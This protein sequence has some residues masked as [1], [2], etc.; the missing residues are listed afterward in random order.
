MKKRIKN[1]L[2]NLIN[3]IEELKKL[4]S[5]DYVSG[6]LYLDFII[7]NIK[8]ELESTYISLKNFLNELKRFN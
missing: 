1:D 7:I 5:S 6:E 8:N 4:V 2:E 3:D